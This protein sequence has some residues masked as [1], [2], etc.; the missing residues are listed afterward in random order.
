M[1]LFHWIFYF[2]TG[3]YVIRLEPALTNAIVE[4]KNIYTQA[5]NSWKLVFNYVRD[6]II[7][8]LLFLIA[9]FSNSNYACNLFIL[10]LFVQFNFINIFCV[11]EISQLNLIRICLISIRS[12]YFSFCIPNAFLHYKNVCGVVHTS[13]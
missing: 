3:V 6:F 8:N 5:L 13:T 10:K 1:S 12:I 2:H 9:K 7:N 4:M 11:S